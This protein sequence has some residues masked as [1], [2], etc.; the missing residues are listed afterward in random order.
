MRATAPRSERV[1]ELAAAR[2][3]V[4]DLGRPRPL[5][6]WT[7]LT[8]WAGAGWLACALAIWLPPGSLAMWI[9]L[10][11]AVAILHRASVFIHE[12]T[13]RRP[14]ELPGFHTA[15]NVIV[16]V[17]LLLPSIFYEGPHADHHVSRSYGTRADP[18][19]L[20][21][22]GWPLGVIVH[23]A[24]SA[25]MPLTL[26]IRFLIVAPVSWVVPP[27]RRMAR[28]RLSTFGFNLAYR[29][30]MTRAEERQLVIWEAIILIAW[31]PALIATAAG[32]L[33]PHWPLVWWAVFAGI[34]GMHRIFE[35]NAHRYLLGDQPVDHAGQLEDTLTTPGPWWTVL[36]A[37][38]GLR[39]HALHHLF[40]RMPF[41]DLAEGHRRLI[42]ELPAGSLYRRS[43][44]PSLGR[45]LIRLVRGPAHRAAPL[46]KAPP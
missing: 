2:A 24:M 29:R 43:L 19:Y 25:I 28:E 37:P 20:R 8:V 14:R 36:W 11:A 17:P 4:R 38:L 40:P 9:A 16:G 31:I 39:Y 10:L 45:G 42:R 33:P 32:S 23:L 34:V 41:H 21:F 35:L 6:Y 13:H 15:W 44:N 5:R 18:E 1:H 12:L 27:V 7:E 46:A 26:V 22:A 30:R 3:L